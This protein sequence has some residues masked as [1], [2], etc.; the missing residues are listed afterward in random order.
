MK[1]AI[2]LYKKSA[3]KGYK[4]AQEMLGWCYEYGIGVEK[5]IKEAIELYL[6]P[7]IDDQSFSPNVEKIELKV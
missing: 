4:Y 2:R 5:N 7:I 6:E 3:K 1:E